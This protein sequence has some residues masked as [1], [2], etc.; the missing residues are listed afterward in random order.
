[1]ID[2][3]HDG[4][5]ETGLRGS[6]GLDKAGR[7]AGMVCECVKRGVQRDTALAARGW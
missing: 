5:E 4:K 7:D 1:M 2:R 3:S 6:L